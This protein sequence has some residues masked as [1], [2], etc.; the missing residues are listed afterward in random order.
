M[1]KAHD[2]IEMWIQMKTNSMDC[3]LIKSLMMKVLKVQLGEEVRFRP[4][5]KRRSAFLAARDI[6]ALALKRG[7]SG[8]GA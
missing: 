6:D 5:R 1:W 7:E 8:S 3:S 2:C 4:L